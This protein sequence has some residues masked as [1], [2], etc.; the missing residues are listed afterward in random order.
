[1]KIN[2]ILSFGQSNGGEMVKEKKTL[3]NTIVEM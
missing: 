1:V 3:Q 2:K